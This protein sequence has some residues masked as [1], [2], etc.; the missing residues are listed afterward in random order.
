MKSH[1]NTRALLRAAAIAVALTAAAAG[2]Q[3]QLQSTNHYVGGSL[4]DTDF[5]TGIRLFGG[6]SLT[7]VFG[8]EAQLASYG[9]QSYQN[10]AYV[11]K[12][13][14][15]TAGVNAMASFN[16]A[17]TLSVFGKAGPHY[18]SFRHSA[19]TGTVSDGTV[20]LG[21]G[22]GLK[23]QFMP[24]AALRADFENIGGSGGDMISVGLQFGL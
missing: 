24:S 16:V 15:W 18:F 20:E 8:W 3:A 23:W 13:S 4:G 7:R 11:Y 2:A 17:P 6:G 5:G 19:P 22:V 21:I 10:G 14:A 9:S 1:R 12:D